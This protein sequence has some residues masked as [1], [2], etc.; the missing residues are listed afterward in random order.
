MSLVEW[1]GDKIEAAEHGED[2]PSFVR[3]LVLILV[4]L[5][6]LIGV[7]GLLLWLAFTW[8]IIGIPVI[9]FLT[10]RLIRWAIT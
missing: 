3:V 1:Y 5:F 10:Y 6:A 2:W 7:C 8:P 4:P 9:A